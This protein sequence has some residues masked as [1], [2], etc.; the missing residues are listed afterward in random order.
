MRYGRPGCWRSTPASTGRLAGRVRLSDLVQGTVCKILDAEEVKPRKVRYCLERR[1]WDF[2]PK[3]AEVTCVYREVKLKKKPPSPSP[4][5]MS[6]SAAAIS[7]L[8]ETDLLTG[9]VHALV[10]DR[11]R[12]REFVEFL[13]L[14]DATYPA[15]TAI[16][17]DPRQSYR[18]HLERDA[19]AGSPNSAPAG[20]RSSSR[21]NMAHGS[22]SSK[23]SFPSSHAR[24][25]ATSASHPGR[26]SRTASRHRSHQSAIRSSTPRPINSTANRV[27]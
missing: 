3:M 5:I 9:K 21:P 23:A 7:L 27:I 11:H 2:A 13:K 4:A 20:S 25:S 18:T 8:A 1:D 22:I 6:R 26:N 19:R 16:K 17:A 14:L 15:H 12:S 24:C 10:E